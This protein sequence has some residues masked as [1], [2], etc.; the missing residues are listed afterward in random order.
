MDTKVP[1]KTVSKTR[2]KKTIP[3]TSVPKTSVPK[4]SVKKTVPK[5]SVP[6]TSVPKKS[7]KRSMGGEPS[8]LGYDVSMRMSN[9]IEGLQPLQQYAVYYTHLNE[10]IKQKILEN[11][12]F[13]DN[14]NLEI[15]DANISKYNGIVEKLI[16]MCHT[17][18]SPSDADLTRNNACYIKIIENIDDGV[19]APR[20]GIPFKQFKKFFFTNVRERHKQKHQAWIDYM[21]NMSHYYKN[22]Y[23]FCDLIIKNQVVNPRDAGVVDEIKTLKRLITDEKKTYLAQYFD[24]YFQSTKIKQGRAQSV[25]AAQH[26]RKTIR[27]R[28]TSLREPPT[29]TTRSSS[30]LTP[31]SP[32]T[33]S[34][35]GWVNGNWKLPIDDLVEKAATVQAMARAAFPPRKTKVKTPVTQSNSSFGKGHDIFRM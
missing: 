10:Y 6:K 1:K 17:N 19:V 5:T 15:L 23:T 25:P 26:A 29:F 32:T 31:N 33:P 22:I 18:E 35:D 2:V 11:S 24:A 12:K 4:T 16:D 21:N 28:P 3:K 20:E 7:V 27:G 34:Q 8:K 14:F 30:S 9:T 13:P